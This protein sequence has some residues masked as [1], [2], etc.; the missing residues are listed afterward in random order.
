MSQLP[1]GWIQTSLGELCT[2]LTDGSHNPPKAKVIG[3]PMLSA[4]NI[5][6]GKLDFGLGSRLITEEEF[7]AEDKRTRISKGD[8]LLT[9][10]GALGRSAVVSTHEKFTL[11]RSVAVL[12]AP[13][14]SSDYLKY[15]IESPSFQ[16]QIFDNAKGT[17]QKGIYLKKLRE[18]NMVLPPLPEQKRIVEKLDEV[19]AQVDTIKA[20]LDGIPELLKCFRQSVL[21]SAVSGKLTEEWRKENK[22]QFD[23][24]LLHSARQKYGSSKYKDDLFNQAVLTLPETPDGWRVIPAGELFSYVTSGSRGWA[25][26]YSDCGALFLRMTNLKYISIELDLEDT[27]YVELPQSVE[28]KRSK[29]ELNDLLISITADVGRVAHVAKD[30]GEAYINQHVALARPNIDRYA[31]YISLCIASE[32]VGIKQVGVLKR[33]ATKAGLGLDD[34]RS[35]AL[36]MPSVDE[37][38]A[39]VRLVDQYFT[40]ADTIEAQVKK[41]QARVDN[42]T[43]SI[44]AKAFRG[45]LV[46]QNDDDEPAEVLLA[47]IAQARKEAEALAKA[48]KK[49]AKAPRKTASKV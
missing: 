38:L 45:E 26:Y 14:I 6:N 22:K 2:K 31:K 32:N 33:G 10:V 34:I 23:G 27:I 42:L 5:Q 13:I 4:K 37:A 25:K 28:G 12:S 8:V 48:A 47:R 18:L 43:Q 15:A 39:I 9:I 19:L 3:L 41:A 16:K 29:V 21:A 24:E 40:F 30:I 17:A 44:L 7:V 1:K 11:Q 46:P 20:R 49:A 36:P 35:F